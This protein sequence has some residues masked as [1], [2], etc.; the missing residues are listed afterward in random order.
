[1]QIDWW[2]LG[3]QLVNLLVLLW[4][5][6]RFLFRP[7]AAMIASRQ[8]QADELLGDAAAKKQEATDALKRAEDERR[9]AAAEHAA[10]AGKAQAEAEAQKAEILASAKAETDARRAEAETA[11]QRASEE[12][13]Q[14]LHHAANLLAGDIAAKLL[15]EPAGKLPPTAFLTRMT[16]AIAALE[17]EEKAALA[18][19]AR[20]AVLTSAHTLSEAELARVRA[21]IDKAAGRSVA[22]SIAVDKALIAGL[23]LDAGRVVVD[24]SLRADLERVAAEL[25]RDDG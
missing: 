4:L 18:A 10:I 14:R 1:M 6:S 2:T 24:A 21:A 16:I 20:P 17:E 15:R 13:A 3:L 25:D 12:E 23:R 19:P 22:F 11:M 9:A 7:I 8:Q 5:L